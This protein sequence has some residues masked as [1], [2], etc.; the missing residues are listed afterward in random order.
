MLQTPNYAL[1]K[2][3]PLINNVDIE[4]IND[5]MDTID[6]LLKTANDRA[7][8]AFL[9]ASNGKVLIKNAITGVDNEVI[10]PT[11]ATFQQLA[12]AIGQIS[13]GVDTSDATATA[14]QILANMVAYVDEVRTVGT[15]ANNGSVGTQ[16]L[17]NQN[18]E[19]IISA[20][21]HNGLGKVK[22]VISNLVAG[23]IKAGSNV[24]GIIGTFTADGTAT[25]AHMLAGAKAYVNGLLVTGNI[26][27][28]AAQTYTPSTVNQT[29]AANQYLSGAQTILGDPD[30]TAPNILN[31]A[32]IFNIQGTA[33]AGKRYATGTAMAN[34]SGTCYTVHGGSTGGYLI[35]VSGLSFNPS[36]VV[37]HY[38]DVTYDS[39]SE[40]T[41]NNAIVYD[42]QSF[43]IVVRT[44]FYSLSEEIGYRAGRLIRV[45]SGACVLTA[46]G[47]TIPVELGNQAYTWEAWE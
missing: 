8:S 43:P 26:A 34:T 16:N 47:F 6:I 45:G 25:A 32:N 35:S 40:L 3:E 44:K 18:A 24:G 31:T 5:N 19:Y 28:K 11:D 20:G 9:S 14:A 36:V 33:I 15:M 1:Q 39:S 21:F 37:A 41:H 17:T 2:P 12:T 4:V 27:S 23:V 42:S 30:L 29:I 46:G 7:D 10:V 13:T 22:A 38:T